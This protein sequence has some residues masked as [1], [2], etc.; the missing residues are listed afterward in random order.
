MF[1]GC[2]T[3]KWIPNI[4]ELFQVGDE[5]VSHT[6]GGHFILSSCLL[7]CGAVL[8][9]LAVLRHRHQPPPHHLQLLRQLLHICLQAQEEAEEG[10]E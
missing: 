9:R 6:E 7:D 4:W 1:I 2:H 5:A 8:A 10:G 3:V